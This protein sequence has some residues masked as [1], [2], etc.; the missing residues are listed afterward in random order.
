MSTALA[1]KHSEGIQ[2]NFPFAE[3]ELTILEKHADKLIVRID[4]PPLRAEETPEGAVLKMGNMPRLPS[5]D[6]VL[7]PV[8]ALVIPGNS[9]TLQLR[10]LEK[11]TG[12]LR[13]L[14]Q[15]VV[16]SGDQTVDQQN[17]LKSDVNRAA[18]SRQFKWV[19]LEDLGKYR[20]IPYSRLR[21]NAV[22]PGSRTGDVSY[23][24][25]IT[26]S[27]QFEVRPGAGQRNISAPLLMQGL[28]GMLPLPALAEA[29]SQQ[30]PQ[31]NS[32][33]QERLKIF[34][35]QEGLYHLSYWDLRSWGAD[36][37]GDPRTFL[38]ENRG[39]EIPI[40][41]DGEADGR[42]DE[43][44]YI[45]FWGEELHDTYSDIN[46]EIYSDLYTDVNVYWLSWGGELG[47]RLVEESGEIVEV[48]PQQMI[49]PTSYHF[50][51][52]AEQNE[53]YNRLSQ[54]G[55]DSL[56]EH[57]YYDSGI[58]APQQNNYAIHLPHPDR[59]AIINANVKVS[60]MG[61]TYSTDPGNNAG[62]HHAY[63]YLNDMTSPSGALQAGTGDISPWRSQTSVFLEATGN[64]G[65][66]SSSL[67]NGENIL[68][69]LCPGDT[70]SGSNDKIL[71]NW[72]EITYPKL[73]K[74]SS[75][76]IRFAPP[77]NAGSSLVDFRLEEFT[78]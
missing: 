21:I 76:Y 32:A 44:D 47:A 37:Y 9:Q 31:S 14:Q 26:L 3:P 22:M 34:V 72:F 58:V 41:V 65:I 12:I 57:W 71:L 25:S 5:V 43:D 62:Y 77:E 39:E 56:K 27:L 69:I 36:V 29:N 30:P 46:P 73:Y 17:P 52:H 4:Y 28:S 8:Q 24:K 13:L 42:F 1:I 51:I 35:S 7:L 16:Y 63:V 10:L 49:R 18:N 60:L 15:P 67:S 40:Y 54:V 68:S 70:R 20:G 64:E 38:L 53:Y 66:R 6:G 48:D 61:L 19:G 23:L 45:E 78:T 75:D 2:A 33:D 74:A 55:P 50:T 11:E 59:D